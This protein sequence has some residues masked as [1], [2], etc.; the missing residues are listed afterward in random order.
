MT[1]GLAFGT[2]SLFG[3][4]HSLSRLHPVKVTND[5]AKGTN[6][7][8]AIEKVSVVQASLIRVYCWR[9]VPR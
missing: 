2:V 3:H 9:A 7:S 1:E 6:S 5:K 4:I 8:A